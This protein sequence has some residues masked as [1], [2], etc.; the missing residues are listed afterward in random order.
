MYGA[1]MQ[2]E[3]SKLWRS[4]NLSL[5]I[6][7]S[8]LAAASGATALAATAGRIA[9]GITA[10]VAAAFGGVLTTVNASHR[11]NTAA[12]AANGYLEI[13]TA[14]RQ[15]REID[16]EHLALDDVR[17]AL[18]ELTARR[19]EQNKVAEPPTARSYR[20]AKTNIEAGSQVYAADSRD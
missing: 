14:A 1:Q 9:A 3:Q 16:L 11:M 18:A 2:F 12:N 20:K 15:L 8:L 17:A 13:Q 10:L 4:V 5:G 19:D 6:P 7:A